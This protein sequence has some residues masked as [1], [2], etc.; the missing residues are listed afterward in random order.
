MTAAP[1]SVWVEAEADGFAGGAYVFPTLPPIGSTIRVRDG[2]GR[3]FAFT[4]RDIEM[5]CFREEDWP[6]VLK[7]GP[8]FGI[9]LYCEKR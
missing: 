7:L 4:V 8:D 1:I 5:D 2:Q 9:I 6:A 3:K